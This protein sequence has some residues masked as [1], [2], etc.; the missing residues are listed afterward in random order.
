AGRASLWLALAGA[1]FLASCGSGG[2][3]NY[4]PLPVVSL[5]P[6]T[7]LVP[8]GGPLQFS[9]SIVSPISTTITWSVNNILGGNSTVGTIS[10]S[11]LYIAPAS[12][13]NPAT[14]TVKA[15]SSAETNPYGSAIV[16][17][18]APVN[19]AVTVAPTDS[20]TPA[21]TTVQFTATVTGTTNT[22]VT[23]SVNGV[24]GGNSTVGT[25][26]NTSTA[27]FYTAPT[28]VPSPPTVVVTATSQAD[29]SDSASTTLTLTASNS[30]PL[31]VNFGLNGN[32]G[33]PNTAYYN[34]LFTT[35]TLCL[36]GNAD[37]QT[38]PDIL[39]DTSSVG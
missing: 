15:T 27:G 22:A 24:A 20:S 31:F 30:A 1:M 16:T 9:A 14:V 4:I 10:P 23:W 34:G 12:V 19:A 13:P 3:G 28:A 18:T 11:G 36:P 21:G 37:C 5:S 25:I 2:T 6:A 38:I 17:I 26:N 39:V 32:T 35:V 8:T 7:A 29:T 33:N